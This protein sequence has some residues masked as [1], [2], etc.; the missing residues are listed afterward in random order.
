ML[1]IEVQAAYLKILRG[2]TSMDEMM[3]GLFEFVGTINSVED[4]H[5]PSHHFDTQRQIA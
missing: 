4:C 1:S 2:K 3:V 5:A